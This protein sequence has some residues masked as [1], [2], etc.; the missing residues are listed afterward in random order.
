M[1]VPNLATRT[2]IVHMHKMDVFEFWILT[3]S[4]FGVDPDFDGERLSRETCIAAAVTTCVALCHCI[5][6]SVYNVCINEV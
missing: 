2:E 4:D 6:K 5:M 3:E 1:L